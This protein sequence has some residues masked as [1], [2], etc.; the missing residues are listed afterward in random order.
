MDYTNKSRFTPVRK[1]ND[2]RGIV[3]IFFLT[4]S[5]LSLLAIIWPTMTALAQQQNASNQTGI[6]NQTELENVTGT[7]LGNKTGSPNATTLEGLEKSQMGNVIPGQQ[8][9]TFEGKNMSA[10]SK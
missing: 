10:I 3:I 7:T 4:L 2:K 9:T 8:N 1:E 6:A 5:L